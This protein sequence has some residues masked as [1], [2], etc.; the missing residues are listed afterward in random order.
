MTEHE[1]LVLARHLERAARAYEQARANIAS[2]L[3]EGAC[4]ITAA[5]F[6]K[7]YAQEARDFA[8]RLRAGLRT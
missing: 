2:D 4:R 7:G 8:A 6:Y 1:R 5:S 3:P